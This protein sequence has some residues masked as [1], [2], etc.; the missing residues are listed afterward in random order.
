MPPDPEFPTGTD[1]PSSDD[2]S[3]TI[4]GFSHLKVNSVRRA[5]VETCRHV[6]R[7]PPGFVARLE[8]H[9]GGEPACKVIEQIELIKQ[10]V[11]KLPCWDF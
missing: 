5:E 3:Q 11:R 6:L 4:F 9:A 2:E 1:T 8:I 10:M 7:S